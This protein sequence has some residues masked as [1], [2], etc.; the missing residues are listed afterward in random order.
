MDIK[1]I[2]N[3]SSLLEKKSFFLFGPRQN[4]ENRRVK[5]MD[6]IHTESLSIPL[7]EH[8]SKSYL[9]CPAD[10]S[11]PRPGVLVIPEF[12]GLTEVTRSRAR[13][14]A[15]DGCCALALD[16]YGGG[17]VGETAAAA[18]DKMNR[19]FS[20][21]DTVSERLK[22]CLSA[23]KNLKQCDENKT[24]SIG[25]CMGGALS[26]HLARMG[27]DVTGVVSFHG[28]LSPLSVPHHTGRIKSK[29]LVCHGSADIMIPKE[30]VLNFKK[31]M[32][33]VQ[34]DCKFVTYPSAKH[35]FTN[36]Q[37]TE[38]GLKFNIPIAYNETADKESYNEML[39][40]FNRI[41]P[42]KAQEA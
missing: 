25:Y 32:E 20:D 9:A 36:P 22:D 35:G 2:L 23:L 19:L 4:R 28:K 14:L 40:F 12:W 34:A 18:A 30:D 38:K 42:G 1:R 31:E 5:T 3:L 11:K 26:L 15:Q 17:W 13:R 24:A 7:G 8:T 27:A 33:E 29:I 21:M 41:F 6:S 16:V 10:Q 37:A 39:R